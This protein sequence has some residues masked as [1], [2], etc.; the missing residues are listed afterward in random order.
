MWVFVIA[1][2]FMIT[3]LWSSAAIEVTRDRESYNI[4]TKTKYFWT[5][6]KT[7]ILITLTFPVILI[8]T[9]FMTLKLLFLRIPKDE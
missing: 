9:I 7:M 6:F 8:T 5:L 1:I 3:L 4:T 2:L